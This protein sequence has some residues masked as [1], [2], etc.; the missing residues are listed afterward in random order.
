MTAAT[1]T[2]SPA[3][4]SAG[5]TG[6]TR[7]H[8]R[9][10]PDLHGLAR[11]P[12]NIL[13]QGLGRR[14]ASAPTRAPTARTCGPSSSPTSAARR[15]ATPSRPPKPTPK[16][17]PT[18]DRRRRSPRPGRRPTAPRRP[19]PHAGPTDAGARA[20]SR[21]TPGPDGPDRQRRPAP[22]Q[23]S[24]PARIAPLPEA[25]ADRRGRH[26]RRRRSSTDGLRSTILGRGPSCCLRRPV[27]GH[28]DA[29]SR[30]APSD[31]L[32]PR[33]GSTPP[34]YTAGHARRSSRR[35][36]H[37]ALRARRDHRRRPEERLAGGPAGEFVA[38]M[39]PSG[40]GKSTLLQLLGGL[41]QPTT[42]VVVLEGET[43]AGSPTTMRRGSAGSGPASSSSPST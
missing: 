38:L 19:D 25:H 41:D 2:S 26:A 1:A 6:P 12:G 14:S 30:H 39:G 8:R 24:P 3:R 7:G 43:S 21:P 36:T 31:R 9:D 13:G 10:P 29:R 40:S 35:T 27:R 28:R 17:T 33:A 34:R 18:P 42:G 32:G 37:E 20:R 16:P 22:T 15:P 4:T 11:P 23:R 5:T